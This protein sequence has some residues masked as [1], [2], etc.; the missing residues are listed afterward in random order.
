[1]K[2]K[3]KIWIAVAVFAFVCC[4]YPPLGL[5]LLGLGLIVGMFWIVFFGGIL[6]LAGI[7]NRKDK[8]A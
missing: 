4:A 2:D 3:V 1:M 5:L 8:D 6:V 7:L